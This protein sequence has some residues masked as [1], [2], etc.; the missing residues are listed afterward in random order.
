MRIGTTQ[1]ASWMPVWTLALLASLVAFPA[2]AADPL[3]VRVFTDKA[4]YERNEQALITMEVKNTSSLSVST[5]YST[6]QQYDFTAHDSSGAV[7]WT[8]SHGK[9]FG[10]LP[11][12]RILAPGETWVIQE[13]WTFADD[14]G[15]SLLDD[16]YSITGT[17]LGSYLGRSGAKTGTQDVVL[18]TSDPL[19]VTFTTDKSSYSRLSSS[20]AALS[21]TVTNAASY[22]VTIDF[23]NGQSFDFSARDSGGQEVWTWSN[24]KTFDPAPTQL[25]LA[26]GESVQ[27]T[28]S[29]TFKNNSGANVADGYYTV[30]GT[31]LG[32]YYGAVPPKSGESQIRVYTL[33]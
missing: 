4:T 33:L 8:W 13:I 9:S 22:P 29:W 28:A 14:A 11:T 31:F 27:F 15:S 20:S 30:S 2:A 5:S 18:F 7:V 10:S 1:I 16:T 32:Q 24:G 6:S 21:L 23:Q 17:F 12:S 19:Q 3:T 26:P 25:V